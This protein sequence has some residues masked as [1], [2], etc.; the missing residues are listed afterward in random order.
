M[1]KKE[2]T[3]IQ[4]SKLIVKEIQGVIRPEER[5]QLDDW[6][7]QSEANLA[8]YLRCTEASLQHKRYQQLNKIDSE[9][10]WKDLSTSLGFSQP[11]APSKPKIFSIKKMLAYA[12]AV[13]V[14]GLGTWYLVKNSNLAHQLLEENQ[15]VQ[16]DYDPAGNKAILKLSDGSVLELDE[17]QGQISIS[18]NDIRYG[19]GRK[20]TETEHVTYASIET[21]RG[22]YYKLILADGTQVQLNASSSISY[23]LKFDANERVVTIT[24][25]AYFDVVE[26]INKPFIVKSKEQEIRVLGTSFNV[27]AYEDSPFTKTTLVR[28]KVRISPKFAKNTADINLT[29]GEQGILSYQRIR[30]EFVDSNQ[31]V[32][33]IHGKFNFDGK[34]LKDVM[35]DLSR[36]YNVDVVYEG[37]IPNIEFFGGTFRDCK[38]STILDLLADDHIEYQLTN[39][40]KLIIRNS[41]DKK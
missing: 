39:D 34:K 40:R 17:N 10:S 2:V 23:P 33:W 24:G 28:G 37:D 16:R 8:T 4:I 30:K 6:K 1:H 9:E 19:N 41:K 5:E 26:N 15:Q 11:S 12:A 3:S 32:A 31:E 35:K 36:W 21:P 38:L 27:N 22:G 18:E 29:A 25:E 20:L 7:N 14:V 13:L